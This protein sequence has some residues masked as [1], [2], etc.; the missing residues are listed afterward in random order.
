MCDIFIR[1]MCR[2]D[3]V[4]WVYKLSHLLEFC[5]H[6]MNDFFLSIALWCVWF[7][8][9][10]TMQYDPFERQ[11][12][13]EIDKLFHFFFLCLAVVVVVFESRFF[14]SFEFC[15]QRD[16]TTETSLKHHSSHWQSQP[17]GFF[18]FFLMLWRLIWPF[19]LHTQTETC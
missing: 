7:H 6:F 10:D 18:S 16:F 15:T 11:Q 14:S 4:Y 13:Y 9:I 3:W 8:L 5:F 2:N 1:W 19:I 12:T 17:T